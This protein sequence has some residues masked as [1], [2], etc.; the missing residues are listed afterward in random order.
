MTWSTRP[1]RNI[2][3]LTPGKSRRYRKAIEAADRGQLIPHEDVMAEMDARID[4]QIK[5]HE[6]RP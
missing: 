6:R 2:W 3:T 1:S 4:E 5:A